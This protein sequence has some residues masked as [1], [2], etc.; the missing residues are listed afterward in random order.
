[1][2]TYRILD[3]QPSNLCEMGLL[4]FVRFGY[5]F[6]HLMLTPMIHELFRMTEIQTKP[7][8]HPFR[9]KNERI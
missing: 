6:E 4:A 2:L 9:R 3:K 8:L 5:S 1:M 7:H